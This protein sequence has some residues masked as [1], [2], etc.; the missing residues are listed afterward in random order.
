MNL[1]KVPNTTVPRTSCRVC[2]HHFYK[3]ALVRYENMPAVAQNLPDA[4]S[5]KDDRG[6]DLNVCQCSGC[7]L[8]QLDTTEPV[9]YYKEIIRA[10]A[11]SPEMKEFR[12]KQFRD[13]V[14]KHALSGKKI[15]EIGSGRGEYLSLMQGAGATASGLEY[16]EASVNS[17]LSVG[18]DVSR[19]FVE[20][21]DYKIK[22]APFDAFF[23]LN[24]LE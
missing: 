1:R 4:N 10:A 17:A 6:F 11:F 22:D 3:Q 18:L 19:G 7:G 2:G 5:L 16:G 15:I 9:S 14:T 23:M 21:E 13:F 20:N 8:V 24:F 12:I